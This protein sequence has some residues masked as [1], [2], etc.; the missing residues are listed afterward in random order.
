MRGKERTSLYRRMERRITPAHAGK[1]KPL[2]VTSGHCW[3][4]PRACGEKLIGGTHSFIRWGSPPRMRGK[5]KGRAEHLAATG[6]T[7]AHAGKRPSPQI[8]SKGRKDHPRACGEKFFASVNLQ[9]QIGSPPRMRGKVA[10][11]DLQRPSPGI[12]PAHAGKS[13]PFQKKSTANRDHPRACGEKT[14]KIP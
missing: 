9:A 5:A 12:T 1:S 8:R 7:P 6:I 13:A 11:T 3:D 4:H 2:A 14:K 10:Y